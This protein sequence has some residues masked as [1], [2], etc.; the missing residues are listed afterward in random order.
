MLKFWPKP[1]LKLDPKLPLKEKLHK[2]KSDIIRS[3]NDEPAGHEDE[4]VG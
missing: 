3:R 1:P 2:F 4:I